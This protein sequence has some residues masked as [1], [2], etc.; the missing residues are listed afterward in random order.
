MTIIIKQQSIYLN[1]GPFVL[2]PYRFDASF[3][4]LPSRPLHLIIFF[5]LITQ[6]LVC[7][8]RLILQLSVHNMRVSIHIFFKLIGRSHFHLVYV[9]TLY[10][11]LFRFVKKIRIIPNKNTEK[12]PYFGELQENVR[13]L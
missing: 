8:E 3:H 10:V 2:F 11:V 13:E 5:T 12:G 4:A 7:F 1:L 6:K 9:K